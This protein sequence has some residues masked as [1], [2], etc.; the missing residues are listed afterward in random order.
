MQNL[1]FL[2]SG[3]I[4]VSAQTFLLR[5][6]QLLFNG[7]ELSIGLVFSLWLAGTAAGSV[8]SSKYLNSRQGTGAKKI[9]GI[10]FLLSGIYTVLSFVFIRE[11]RNIFGFLPG[12]ALSPLLLMAFSA[13]IFV[14]LGAIIGYQFSLGV[15][16]L[17]SAAESFKSGRI[18]LWE[19]L[20]F[21]AGGLIYTALLLLNVN[22]VCVAL[23][24]V[25][26]SSLSAVLLA[27]NGKLKKIL[28]VL[29]VLLVPVQIFSPKLENLSLSRLFKGYDVVDVKNTPYGQLAV[30]SRNDERF[31]FSDGNPIETFN[32]PNREFSENNV[33]LPLLFHPGPKNA[34]LIGGTGRCIPALETYG[35]RELDYVELNPWSID[36][37]SVNSQKLEKGK[38]KPRIFF[39]GGLKA[40]DE[41]P[42]ASLRTKVYYQDGRRFVENSSGHYDAVFLDI[43]YPV[44]L[45]LNRFYTLEFFKSANRLV[46]TDGIFVLTLPGS[47]SYVDKYLGGL[48]WQITAG[49]KKS[50]K[51][52]RVIPGEFNV[53]VC[54]NSPLP[55]T[56]AVKNRL[57]NLVAAT[58]F[59]SGKYIEYK[60]DPGKEQWLKGEI[61]KNS[62]VLLGK[63]LLNTDFNPRA[64]FRGLIYW[65]S[66]FSFK[67][68]D[69]YVSISKYAWAAFAVILLLVVFVFS[70]YSAV[71]FGTGAAAMGMQMIGIWGMQ[72]LNGAVYYWIGLLTACFMAGTGVAAYTAITR[73]KD[74]KITKII[75]NTEM[76]T[77]VW[78]ILWFA[79]L[80]FAKIP[81][82]LIFI[83]S[84][85]SGMLLGLQFPWLAIAEGELKR[86][87]ETA[88][89]GKIYGYDLLGGCFAAL[90]GGTIVIP[91]WGL[92]GMV[93]M[94]LVLKICSMVRVFSVKV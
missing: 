41:G 44:S 23:C 50:F 32:Q 5:E 87:N 61:A 81:W 28:I 54:S 12:I 69:A 94:L 91:A 24:L 31:F 86:T 89:S 10:S 74:C 6:L 59:L 53:F 77:I 88:E 15:K 22:S 93:I 35:I 45:S 33:F 39:P 25:Q 55:E 43:V 21:L 85:G 34:L 75:K 72:I 26:L 19:S 2:L 42:M 71:S 27:E 20:G 40:Q 76:L 8:F 29:V 63:E 84:T 82:Y 36:F 73:F 7:N 83:L 37:V 80:S 17:G 64:L 18:Y 92:T 16:W 90:I 4:A 47:M 60:L 65:Q 30:V 13:L 66:I 11:I 48:T 46:G 57:K 3:F 51:Y 1:I 56:K 52:T 79:L 14:P 38:V 9:L 67:S 58:Y 68:A 62:D 49:L 70:K 78:I